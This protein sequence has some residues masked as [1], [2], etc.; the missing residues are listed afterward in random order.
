MQAPCSPA[1]RGGYIA[2][3]DAEA[4]G[5]ASR[6]ARA[7]A[8]ASKGDRIDPAVGIEVLHKVE[9]VRKGEPLFIV[10]ANDAAKLAEARESLLGAV[11]W[12]AERVRKLPLFYKTIR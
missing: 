10:H 6:G 12:K 11:K 8:A 1:P 3:I 5:R 4:M 2:A 9:R 7:R